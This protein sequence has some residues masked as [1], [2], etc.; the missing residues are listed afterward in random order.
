MD[1]KT[2]LNGRWGFAGRGNKTTINVP[3][4]WYLEGRDFA[5]EAVYSREFRIKKRA[6][7]RYF[8]CFKGVDYFADVYI[9]SKK[10]GA[11]EGYFQEFRFDITGLIKDGLNEARVA[12]NSPKEDIKIWPDK[13]I[14]IK[15]IFNHHDAR[16]GSWDPRY[17][18]DRNTGGIWNDVY[19]KECAAVEVERVKITPQLKSDGVW[20]VTAELFINN[21]SQSY[22]DAVIEAA[23]SPHNFKG[24]RIKI[25]KKTGLTPGLNRVIVSRDMASP[26]LWWTWDMGARN[27]YSFDCAV[28]AAGAKSAW[29]DTFGIR[30]F[31]RG[32]DKCWY[33]NGKRI[34]LRG[35][36]I[37]PV[38][39]LSEYSDK[40]IKR[41]AALIREANLNMIRVHAHVNRQEFYR[42]LDREGIMVWQ[43]FA[44]QWG[45]ET[46][47]SFMENASSQ[48]K[49]MV[50][51][52]Y[53]RPSIVLWCCHNEPWVNEKQLDPVLKKR[54]AEEDP[55]RV[56]EEA[57]D[58]KQHHYP[59]W[60]YDYTGANT[61]QSLETTKTP[62]IVTEYG[63][64][65]LPC[66]E[67]MKKIFA[68]GGLW[69]PDWKK[70]AYHDFQY[71]QTFNIAGVRQ[72]DS[73][74]EFVENSQQYQAALIKE[75]TELYRLARYQYLNGLLHFMM[76]EC[77]PSITW[78]VVDYYRLPKK[79]FYALKEAMQPIYP[80][81]RLMTKK[82]SKGGQIGWG[83]L[84]RMM[85]FINDTHCAV[86][87]ARVK[88]VIT[89]GAGRAYFNK[90]KTAGI[91]EADSIST[92]FEAGSKD[93]KDN[94]NLKVP[95]KCAAGTHTIHITLASAKGRVIASN[96]YSF[97]VTEKPD[98][99]S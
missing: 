79:G 85:F 34:F 53:N 60:Y 2:V 75:L 81:Y 43:D 70:W 63:A 84:W 65:A 56:I 82:I 3:A 44:L 72:G 9:N 1:K 68:G 5:G 22:E 78:A 51:L 4:N 66:L 77:W 50:N 73:I 21:Y 39:F 48:I 37:I 83:M 38:Q 16:P 67:T 55:V 91:I 86:K 31:K 27:L 33:L 90:S 7:R 98:D 35:S 71:E 18:Q 94:D 89:D 59:G 88:V 19:I 46:S 80:G 8:I 58:F 41:D 15:G 28:E 42:E 47:G 13:K 96:S 26:K 25:S 62:F 64:Q 93:S 32:G 76:V 23:V 17:G 69:P 24:K 74:E 36:N 30:E 49:D 29:S 20:N 87:N 6:D 61:Q 54:A 11:H 52:F 12:V 97:T 45:Y 40:M 92:P 57:S 99:K 10:A 95:E 14:L